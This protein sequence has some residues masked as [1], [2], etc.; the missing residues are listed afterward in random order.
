MFRSLEQHTFRAWFCPFNLRN[1]TARSKLSK[2]G[3]DACVKPFRIQCFLTDWGHHC[4]DR[5]I[6]IRVRKTNLLIIRCMFFLV[7]SGRKL[8]TGPAINCLQIMACSWAVPSKSILLQIIFCSCV[9]AETTLSNEKWHITSMRE[10]ESDL[11][12]KQLLNSVIE[13][14]CD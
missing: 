3:P 11:N 5:R 9:I 10:E 2:A 1:N 4:K 12:M 13:K 14:V 7:S 6:D 8:N